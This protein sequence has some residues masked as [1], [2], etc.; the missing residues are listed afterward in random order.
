MAV[1][2]RSSTTTKIANNNSISG[3]K[4]AGLAVGDL[5]IGHFSMRGSS[6]PSAPAGWTDID[7]RT[8]S[9][10]VTSLVSYKIADAS[11]VAASNFTFTSTDSRDLG[12]GLTAFT[13]VNITNPIGSDI[14]GMNGAN[15]SSITI[16]GITPDNADSAIVMAVTTGSDSVGQYSS[17]AI[18]VSDPTWTEVYDYSVNPGS[19]DGQIGLAFGL[20]PEVSATGNA[21][22]SM[23]TTTVRTGHLFA[24]NPRVATD[25]GNFIFNLL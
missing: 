10:D 2:Y 7:E 17:W 13:G 8:H 1:G 4:P 22:V 21:T 24:I 9:T 18:A 23:N 19:V 12:L 6:T 15:A 3:N 14:S 16:A 5:L 11:D 20:R 25:G